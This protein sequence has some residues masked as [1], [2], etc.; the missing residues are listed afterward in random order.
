MQIA[1]MEAVASIKSL[2]EVVI[3]KKFLVVMLALMM[4]AL[5]VTSAFAAGPG[6]GYGACPAQGGQITPEQQQ[7]FVQF[8]NEILPL[9]QK[10]LQLRTELMNLRAQNPTDWKAVSAKQK[11]MVDVRIAIQQKASESG[12][13]GCRGMGR[14][15]GHGPRGGYGPGS[16][17]QY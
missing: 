12:F 9:K 10:M 5:L 6:G 14:M 11:E 16:R 3:M 1:F 4:G 2:K 13:D 7:K 17:G 8:Q 15:G